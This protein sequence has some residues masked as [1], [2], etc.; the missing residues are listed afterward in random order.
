MARSISD[1]E[2]DRLEELVD[3]VTLEHVLGALA[4]VCLMKADHIEESYDDRG[5]AKIWRQMANKLQNAAVQ[6]NRF[7]L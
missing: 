1:R 5:L 3:A 4:F 2:T 7:A 6:A